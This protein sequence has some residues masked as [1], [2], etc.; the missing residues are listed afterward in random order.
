MAAKRSEGAQSRV[1]FRGRW[2]RSGRRGP[3]VETPSGGGGREAVG[4]GPK[5]SPFSGWTL[6]TKMSSPFRGRWPRSGRRGPKTEPLQGEVAAKRSE[7]T[8]S[9]DPFR[10]RWPRS[11]RRGPKV[12]PPSGTAPR[13]GPPHLR[14]PC[15]PRT[16]TPTES[17]APS[18]THLR[19]ICSHPRFRTG[20]APSPPSCRASC[21]RCGCPGASSGR[22]A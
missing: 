20:R 12:E 17:T 13:T 10:G 18:Q 14:S 7:G 5:Q 1:P 9:R 6:R 16:P 22:T 4:G 8:Q 21:F 19:R 11:G 15:P 2:P 3:K